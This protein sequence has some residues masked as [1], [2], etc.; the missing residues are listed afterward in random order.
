MEEELKE[1]GKGCSPAEK[2]KKWKC[3]GSIKG[4]R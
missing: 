3:E 4:L 1:N 2:K